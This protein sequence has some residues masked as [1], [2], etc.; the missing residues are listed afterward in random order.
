VAYYYLASALRRKKDLDGAVAA[1]QEAVRLLPEIDEIRSQM[2]LVVK[3]RN[4]RAGMAATPQTDLERLQGKWERVSATKE[5]SIHRAERVVKQ[6]K[7]STVT[8]TSYDGK[9]K[10]LQSHKA[11]FRLI[12]TGK[13]RTL[14]YSNVEVVDGPDKGRKG[15]AGSYIYVLDGDTFYE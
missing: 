14:S 8:V 13:V 5:S 15:A 9:G 1:L 2:D 6:I 10:M 7:G 12:R 4:K 11:T 3:E